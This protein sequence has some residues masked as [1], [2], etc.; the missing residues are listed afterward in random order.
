MYKRRL[1]SETC[2][3]LAKGISE[4]AKQSQY[5]RNNLRIS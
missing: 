2:K 3:K 4:V 1:D 5:I